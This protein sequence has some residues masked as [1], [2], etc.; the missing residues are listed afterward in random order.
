MTILY[1]I[2]IRDFDMKEERAEGMKE[3]IDSDKHKQTLHSI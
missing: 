1:Q 2:H 3:E